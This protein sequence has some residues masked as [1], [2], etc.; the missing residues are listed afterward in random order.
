MS[1]K[2]IHKSSRLLGVFIGIQLLLL[3][4]DSFQI[5]TIDFTRDQVYS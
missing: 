5:T 3:R 4:N 2:Y 1:D